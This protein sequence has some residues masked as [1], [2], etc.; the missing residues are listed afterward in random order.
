MSD[1]ALA[2]RPGGYLKQ[3]R[4]RITLWIAA[5]EG[6][7]VIVHVLPK[8]A[9]YALCAIALVFWFAVARNYKSSLARQSGW[10]LAASQSVAVLV[11]IVWQVTKLFVAIAIVVVVAAA[12]L[13]F[14]F[15]ERDKHE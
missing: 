14:L 10:I 3:H 6:L 4:L 7:L 2:S 11:P 5:A 13:Y 12:A 15:A 1:H 9:V 8:Y